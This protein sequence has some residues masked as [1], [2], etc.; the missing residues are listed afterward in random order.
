MGCQ[1]RS[2]TQ[3]NTNQD[4]TPNNWT[5]SRPIAALKIRL[6]S[7]ASVDSDLPGGRYRDF[8]TKK[9]GRKDPVL[10][11]GFASDLRDLGFGSRN[12]AAREV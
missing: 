9:A 3:P 5:W 6:L 11:W 10:A 2:S 4:S 12:A 1:A 7:V 8:V